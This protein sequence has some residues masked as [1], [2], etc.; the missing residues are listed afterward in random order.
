MLGIGELIASKAIGQTVKTVVKNILSK[1]GFDLGEDDD[2]REER[3]ELIHALARAQ[4]EQAEA[5]QMANAEK[6]DKEAAE[7]RLEQQ[8]RVLDL[9]E[10][11]GYN[12]EMLVE[13]YQEE[14]SLSIILV[15]AADKGED[16][17]NT[18]L[19]DKL[20]NE[21]NAEAI[22][23]ALKIIPPSQVPESVD[24]DSDV[25]QWAKDLV[26]EQPNNGLP[27]G[28]YF[29][30]RKNIDEVYSAINTEEFD[31]GW[32]TASEVVD[33][34]LGVDDLQ[35]L[36]NSAPVSPISLVRDGDIH[37]LA[38]GV[39]SPSQ[40]DSI[41]RQQKQIASEL[42]DPDLRVLAEDI[43]Q[44][45]MESALDGVVNTPDKAADALLTEAKRIHQQLR[46]SKG[47][48]SVQ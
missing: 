7:E 48:T 24:S 44:E 2:D 19:K 42:G 5:R 41:D 46:E 32:K 11:K 21:Y 35:G 3:K 23:G 26:D 31:N 38:H 39:L 33:D 13:R 37:F 17:E 43:S 6:R 15:A 18:Y 14:N 40:I 36:I 22:A 4:K 10:R 25:E 34:M 47:I 45:T 8:K 16:S 20:N 28:I 30:T 9:M 29:A 27:S 1:L 12:R